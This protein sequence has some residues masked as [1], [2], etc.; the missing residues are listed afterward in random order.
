MLTILM[1]YSGFRLMH[2]NFTYITFERCSNVEKSNQASSFTDCNETIFKKWQNFYYYCTTLLIVNLKALILTGDLVEWWSSG[3]IFN[4]AIP[5][6][7]YRIQI[8][9]IHYLATWTNF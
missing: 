9:S 3:R 7:E 8:D 1:M 6:W 4:H 5:I 2:T